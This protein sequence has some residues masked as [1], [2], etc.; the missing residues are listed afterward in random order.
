[1]SEMLCRALAPV[2]IRPLARQVRFP[3]LV[4]LA[5]AVM[6]MA[7]GRLLSFCS[8]MYFIG[9]ISGY[10][11]C[12]GMYLYS[13]THCAARAVVADSDDAR[14]IE[15]DT[16]GGGGDISPK[17]G[18]RALRKARYLRDCVK[19]RRYLTFQKRQPPV[20]AHSP[21]IGGTRKHCSISSRGS[22]Y[23]SRARKKEK[24]FR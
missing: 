20:Q 4:K 10:I 13:H 2:L 1:M 17:S 23:H 5:S 8:F 19:R 14:D 6:F 21:K 3:G 9:Y 7:A 11:L 24:H 12:M 15:R 16:G 18:R 22:E